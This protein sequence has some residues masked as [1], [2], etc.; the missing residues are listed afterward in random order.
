MNYIENFGLDF[1]LDDE[2][3]EAFISTVLSE[4]KPI[5]GYYGRPYV[6]AEY[7]WPQ[8]IVRTDVNEE[9]NTF[10]ISGIDTHL[11]GVTQWT[12][13]LLGIDLNSEDEDKLSRRVIVK[14][15]EDGRGITVLNLVNADVLPS[16]MENDVITAQ[17]VG[18]PEWIRYYRDEDAYAEDQ[19]DMSDEKKFL[20]ADGAMMPMG[21]LKNRN[22]SNPDKNKDPHSDNYMMIRGTVN[23]VKPGLCKFGDHTFCSFWDV[24]INTDF[25]PL[26]IVHTSDMVE[27]SDLD[28][29]QVGSV[30]YGVF[31]LSGD[32]AIGKYENG[33][34]MDEETH[35]S[36]FRYSITEGD[37]ERLRYVLADNAQYSSEDSKRTVSGRDDIIDRIQHVNSLRSDNKVNVYKA[38]VVSVDEGEENLPYG[39]GKRCLVL[40]YDDPNTYDSIAFLDT[41]EKGRI[42]NIH[43]S[44]NPRYRFQLDEEPQYE[45]I[46]DHWERP[47][48]VAVPMI[49]RAKF[50]N[51]LDDETSVESVVAVGDFQ[52]LYQDQAKTL[53]DVVSVE[54]DQEV[55]EN[56]FGY[57]FAK[58]IESTYTLLLVLHRQANGKEDVS[59][60][61][62]DAVNG[63]FVGGVENEVIDKK[64]MI[65]YEYG[66]QFFKDFRFFSQFDRETAQET[67]LEQALIVAQ[68]IGETYAKRLY[69]KHS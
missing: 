18:F 49:N 9:A 16:F 56:V 50:H 64:I 47:D 2:N 24:V 44:V 31:V 42:T 23:S 60:C 30:V 32:V 43:I 45:S 26:E 46:T 55:L 61:V 20:L 19:P 27:E 62:D 12:V 48:S 28:L 54:S 4:G 65:A 34:V 63:V 13:S 35:L 1:L 66:K 51:F 36:L 37:P 58:A 67:I 7:G 5:I 40:A 38:T 29:I 57:V 22:A 17:V 15:L 69:K 59:Y 10:T 68:Q 41:N 6:N 53:L 11:S 52:K 14:R 25:G 33:F 21:L 3:G 39:E 8:F